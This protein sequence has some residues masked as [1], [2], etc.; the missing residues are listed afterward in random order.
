MSWLICFLQHL[1]QSSIFGVIV[2]GYNEGER[3]RCVKETIE[4]TVDGE[5][6]GALTLDRI[7]FISASE[8]E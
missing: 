1:K 7:F 2:G 5:K 4:K 3:L 8:T 6:I